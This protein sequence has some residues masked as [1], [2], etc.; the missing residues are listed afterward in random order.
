MEFIT[1]LLAFILMLGGIVLIHEFGHFIAA[2]SFGVHCHEF[3]I[4]M[5]PK[6]WSRQGKNTMFSIRAIPLGGYVMM[7][8][9]EDGS[10]DEETDDWL[11]KV[12]AEER[13]N[14][15]PVW[16]QIIVM[17]AGVCMNFLLAIVLFIGFAGLKGYV[18]EPAL[19]VVYEVLPDSAAAKAG[20]MQGDRIVKITADDGSVLEPEIQDDVVEFIQYHHG[21]SEFV[22]ERQGQEVTLKVTPEFDKERQAYLLGITSQANI[23]N[24]GWLEAIPEGFRLFADSSTAIFRSLGMLIRGQGLDQL[25]GPVGIY[26][27]TSQVVSYGFLPFVSLCAMLS[28][29]VGIFNLIPIPALDGGRILILA[30]ESIFRRKIPSKVVEGVILASFV[31]LIGLMLFSTYNDIMRLFM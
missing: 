2:R 15:K 28:V 24:I 18:Q 7:A 30:L 8:G 13:L 26:Q 16:Q 1:G 11:A 17:A 20:L 22:L 12:P 25:S 27:V 14:N 4:G 3:S 29:N 6:L 19:P 31:L 21:E 5:G 23:R 9:E 10:Q